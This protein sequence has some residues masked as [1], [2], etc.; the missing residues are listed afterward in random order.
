MPATCAAATGNSLA[1]I[2]RLLGVS[3]STIFKWIL[4]SPTG[5]SPPSSRPPRRRRRCRAHLL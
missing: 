3:P 2:A 5:G 1:S 4:N